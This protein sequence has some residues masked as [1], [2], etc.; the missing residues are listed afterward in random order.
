MLQFFSD[1]DTDLTPALA[2]QYNCR[3]ISM[4]FS[5]AGKTV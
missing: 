1:T 4:P 5:I 3:L 2:K